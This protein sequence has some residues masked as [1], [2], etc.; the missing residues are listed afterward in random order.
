MLVDTCAVGR[1]VGRLAERRLILDQPAEQ[2]FRHGTG[3][4]VNVRVGYEANILD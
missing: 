4:K 2:I 3:E 1:V